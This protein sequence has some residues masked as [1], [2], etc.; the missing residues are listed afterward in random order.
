MHVHYMYLADFGGQKRALNLGI[1]AAGGCKS[2]C[3]LGI[4]PG[5]PVRGANALNH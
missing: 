2:P 3:G 1:G 5:S 4:E